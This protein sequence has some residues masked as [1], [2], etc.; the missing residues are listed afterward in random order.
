MSNRMYIIPIFI[1]H[2]G[3]NNMCVFCNQRKISGELK[4][5][6]TEDIKNIIDNYLNINSV[7]KYTQIQVAFYGGSFTGIETEKQIEFL[8]V[9]KEYIDN[10][11]ISSIRLSTRPDY[12]SKEI[13]TYL[14]E[15][16]VKTIE[17]GVQSL[18][19]DVL[20]Y[21]KRGHNASRVYES[22]KMIKEY[23]FELGLQ[24]ML[25]LPHS[26]EEFEIETAKKVIEMKPS[27]VRIYPTLVIKD[28]ELAEMYEKG[29]YIPYTVEKAVDISAKLMKMYNEAGIIVIRTGL[30]NTDNIRDGGDVIA[31]PFHP[32]FGEL[33]KQRV[34]RNDI[35]TKISDCNFKNISI[36]CNRKDISKILGNK[37]ENIK[38]L[39]AKFNVNIKI[40][41][42]NNY[43]EGKYELKE[44]V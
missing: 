44:G 10:K 5:V 15:Y 26:N 29:E 42:N 2:K 30:Q 12:I 43:I 18:N 9:A 32:A 35:E 28:T 24:T 38:Y 13:L 34:Y 31:G 17:L 4:D 33:V 16:G 36:I 41:E 27:I 19:E 1:P 8:K 23:G 7:I 6:T 37:K 21:S 14:K 11:K 22:A 40:I 25:G 3:C 39:N 20:L